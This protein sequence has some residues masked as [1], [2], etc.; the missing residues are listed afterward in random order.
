LLGC[1]EELPDYWPNTK[2]SVTSIRLF[3]AWEVDWP[4]EKKMP[5][6]KALAKYAHR[7]NAKVLV[8]TQISCNEKEDDADWANVVQLIKI[9]GPDS[10][11]GIAVGNEL[12]LLQ[13]KNPK[14]IPPACV[15]KVWGGYFVRKFDERVADLDKMGGYGDVKLTSVFGAAINAGFPFVNTN[16]A[17]VLSFFEHV[18]NKYGKRWVYSLNIYPY[19]DPGNVLDPGTSD[20][21][22]GSLA[23]SLCW[24]D[25]LAPRSCLLPAVF[26]SMRDRLADLKRMN[27]SWSNDVVWVTETGWSAPTAS[28]LYGANPNMGR[29]KDFSSNKSLQ[30]YYSGFLSWDLNIKHTKGPDHVFYFTVHDSNN[31]GL[32][33][34]FGLLGTCGSQQCKI[35]EGYGPIPTL[36]PPTPPPG[37]HCAKFPSCK[38]FHGY[39]CPAL[40]GTYSSCCP[41]SA[42]AACRAH[43]KCPQNPGNCCPTPSGVSLACC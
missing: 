28:S 20:K 40:N 15:L 9:L 38:G 8:G 4:Q 22:T 3:K 18:L 23:R 2:E 34:H 13:Y 36:H 33:E 11:M 35:Q 25:P 16:K 37:A 6:W 31:F 14:S 27:A 17:K 29:C 32:A 21:C 42:M 41:A 39:C 30:E 10:V 26:K 24:D 12:E 19:F 7:N 5:A 43:P 1:P